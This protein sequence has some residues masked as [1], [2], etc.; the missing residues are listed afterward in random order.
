MARKIDRALKDYLEQAGRLE[1]V[2]LG[3]DGGEVPAPPGMDPEGEALS[4]YFREQLRS[5]QTLLRTLTAMLCVVFLLGT[6]TAIRSLH[7][8]QVMAGL[9]AGTLAAMLLVVDFLRR[10][11][12]EKITMDIALYVLHN[13]APSETLRML[14]MIYWNRKRQLSGEAHPPPP[15]RRAQAVQYEDFVVRIRPDRGRGTVLESSSPAGDAEGVLNVPEQLRPGVGLEETIR[16]LKSCAPTPHADARPLGRS[17]FQGLFPE[18]VRAL[19][20]RCL[21]RVGLISGRGLRIRL[22]FNPTH[23]QLARISELPW[24]LLC[25]TTS[26]KFVSQQRLTPIVRV[27]EIPH[28]PEPAALVPPLRI[29][30]VISMPDAMSPLDLKRER[31]L[32]EAILSGRPQVEIVRLERPTLSALRDRLCDGEFHILHYMGHGGLDPDTG[33][34][35]LYFEDRERRFVPVSGRDL[36]HELEDLPSL[37]LAVI[38]A[39]HSAH[40]HPPEDPVPH[41]FAGVATSLVQAGLTSVVAMQFAISDQG[42]IAFSKAFYHR[43]AAGDPVDAAVTEGRRELARRRAESLEWAAPVLFLRAADGRVLDLTEE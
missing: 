43:L 41:R 23:S 34:G 33:E 35:M 6:I 3:G 37:R 30:M 24:E 11:W 25:S 12:V 29:L 21:G 38:N 16:D 26:G 28:P 4:L 7:A 22:A 17:L 39:C 2:K 40:S 27:L 8:P 15:P 18:E 13:L 42:A 36:G 32:I 9:L 10:I 1:V 14:E 31:R 5:H 19:Y 20:E